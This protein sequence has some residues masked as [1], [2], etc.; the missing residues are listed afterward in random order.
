VEE[1]VSFLTCPCCHL[2]LGF[3]ASVLRVPYCPRCLARRHKPV[4]LVDAPALHCGEE[5]MPRRDQSSLR[6]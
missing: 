6:R 4:E 5:H 2:T 3:R 1:H